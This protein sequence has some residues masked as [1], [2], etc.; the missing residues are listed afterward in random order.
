MAA[1]NHPMTLKWFDF[2]PSVYTSVGYKPN[3][4][5]PTI[6]GKSLQTQEA[7]E[8]RNII[9]HREKL[10][11]YVSEKIRPFL[12]KV[13]LPW[14]DAKEDEIDAR[15]QEQVDLGRS[16]TA[17]KNLLLDA[18]NLAA[19]KSLQYKILAQKNREAEK[20]RIN[21]GGYTSYTKRRWDDIN[22]YY[23]DGTGT[24]NAGWNPVADMTMADIWA[25]A[26]NSTPTR[27]ETHGINNTTTSHVLVDNNGNV[28]VDDYGNPVTD[29]L[30]I[31]D[32]WKGIPYKIQSAS[33]VS[34][35]K[36]N[37]GHITYGNNQS[38]GYN[39]K[40][41]QDI[42]NTFNSLLNDQNILASIRQSFDN[43]VWLYNDAQKILN[44]PNATEAQ[45]AQAKA[46]M[47]VV[48]QNFKDKNGIIH[49]EDQ[50]FETWK[51]E[52]AAQYAGISAYKHIS[53]NFGTSITSNYNLG[54]KDDVDSNAVTS[55]S[56]SGNVQTQ[57]SSVEIPYT[58]ETNI[59]SAQGVG[60]LINP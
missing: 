15:Y 56:P 9:N 19:S 10:T 4:P 50:Y 59:P 5:D 60:N 49:T 36:D 26:V 48:E 1:I 20:A 16:E 38:I 24:W 33:L 21:S 3:T 52:Q 51:Q 47:T 22:K 11:D 40:T 12:N 46:D 53:D 25:R 18:D 30:K 37:I 8:E 42:I 28:I 54:S 41:K 58:P 45:I 27:Q 6:Q 17:F 34:G 7:R 14:L 39:E 57:G 44:D 13:E 35:I 23:D 32:K 43:L 31:P 29:P 55:F 2:K